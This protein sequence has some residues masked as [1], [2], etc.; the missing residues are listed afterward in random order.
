MC[1]RGAPTHPV[2]S[3]VSY[4]QLREIYTNNERFSQVGDEIYLVETLG[5]H[6]TLGEVHLGG[7]GRDV[8]VDVLQ[9]RG[10]GIVI[11]A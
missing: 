8:D 7:E 5:K 9:L 2:L 10:S 3:G 4:E 11:K 6:G 1:I